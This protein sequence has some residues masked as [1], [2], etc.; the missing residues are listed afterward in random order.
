MITLFTTLVHSERETPTKLVVLCNGHLAPS[1]LASWRMEHTLADV[2][3]MM[4]LY[5]SG[6]RCGYSILPVVGYIFAIASFI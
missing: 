3:E 5:F 1:I 4:V 6:S 2:Y